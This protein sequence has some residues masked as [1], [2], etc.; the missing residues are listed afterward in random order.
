MHGAGADIFTANM[1]LAEDRILCWELVS[2]RGGSWILHYVKSAYAVTDVPDQ[3]PELISQRR[4]WLNGSFFA[5]VHST[6]HFHYIYRSSHTFLRKFWIHIEMVYQCYNLIFSW[7]SLGNYYIAFVILTNAL[8]DYISSV[9]YVNLILNYFYLGL[10]ITCFLLSLGNRPQGA[11]WAYT[12]AFVGFGLITIYMTVSA[13]LLAYKGIEGVAQSEGRAVQA[14]DLF[15]NSIF[16]DIVLSLAATLGLYIIASLLFFEPWHM[17]TSF[18]QYLLMAPSYIAVLNVYAFANVHDVSWGTKGDNKVSTDLGVVSVGKGANKNEVEVAVP[19]AETDIN[20]AYEDAIHVLSTKPPKEEKKVDPATQ[21]E[22]YY[23]TFRTNV[24]M[25]WVLSN[26]L[27]AAIVVE[28]T[29]K[30]GSGGASTAVNGYMSFIL[31]SVAGLAFIRFL[32]ST[33]YL[34]VRLFAGE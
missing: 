23:K 16:R 14:S 18:V 34:L 24:L 27:L 17:I 15:T 6:F 22:D 26:A 32:G 1:Y 9:H 13:F 31:F 7:F 10:L 2:K 33:A 25:V 5:A 11:K 3:V 19:T 12:L 29:P 21:Q 8:E 20:A 28:A 4:R 30:A